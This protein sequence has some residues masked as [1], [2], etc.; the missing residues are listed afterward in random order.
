MHIW[1]KQPAL[2]VFCIAAAEGLC[3]AK[4]TV[5]TSV[6]AYITCSSYE[7]RCIKVFS[8]E[9]IKPPFWPSWPNVWC[10]RCN[11]LASLDFHDHLSFIFANSKTWRATLQ[12]VYCKCCESLEDWWQLRW[13]RVL[14]Q[15]NLGKHYRVLL[16]MDNF[17][18]DLGL[19]INHMTRFPL[20]FIFGSSFGILDTVFHEMATNSSPS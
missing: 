7:T 3:F 2:C 5:N 11:R 12:S 8:C 9:T 20:K 19:D 1:Y 14:K 4:I 6:H 13:R 15:K 18:R 10:S 16:V 17:F